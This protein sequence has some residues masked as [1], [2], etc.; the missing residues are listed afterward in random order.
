[1]T[2]SSYIEIMRILNKMDNEYFRKMKEENRNPDERTYY[3]NGLYTIRS[4]KVRVKETLKGN[5]ERFL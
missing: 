3:R 4:V 1:M 2:P 5:Q